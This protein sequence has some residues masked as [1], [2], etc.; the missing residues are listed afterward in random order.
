MKI[1]LFILLFSLS[2]IGQSINI[3]QNQIPKNAFSEQA[4][5]PVGSIE[6]PI[7]STRKKSEGGSSH[8]EIGKIG[9]I[10]NTLI[11]EPIT[12]PDNLSPV[13]RETPDSV[14]L[15]DLCVQAARE[16]EANRLIIDAQKN[17]ISTLQ[18]GTKL[19]AQL[20]EQQ[21]NI[22]TEYK[23]QVQDLKEDK[24][25]ADEIISKNNQEIANLKKE[26]AIAQKNKCGLFCQFTRVLTGVG[27][28]LIIGL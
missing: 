20:N 13:P 2:V 25:K 26:L 10:E 4:Q 12:P 28:G 11:K 7:G 27:I 23:A 5:T 9:S 24:K 21:Q 14:L 6:I 16:V 22:I 17:Y 15:H 8:L 3:S 18:E 1:L 19:A